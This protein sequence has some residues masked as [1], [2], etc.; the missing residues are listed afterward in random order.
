M[1][2][3]KWTEAGRTVGSHYSCASKSDGGSGTGQK[4]VLFEHVLEV[5]ATPPATSCRG[6]GTTEH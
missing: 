3:G 1:L 2:C 4:G 5:E 6:E